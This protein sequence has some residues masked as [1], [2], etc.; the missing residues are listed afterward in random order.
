MLGD[1]EIELIDVD[2]AK[3]IDGLGGQS[4]DEVVALGRRRDTFS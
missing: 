3:L 2:L 1:V 4:A